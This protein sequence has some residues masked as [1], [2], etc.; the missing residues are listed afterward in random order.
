MSLFPSWLVRSLPVITLLLLIV[1]TGVVSI[2]SSAPMPPVMA[3][4]ACVYYWAMFQPSRLPLPALI[5][6]GLLQD[7][8]SGFPLGSSALCLLLLYYSTGNLRRLMSARHFWATWSGFGI[9]AL[10]MGI[11]MTICFSYVGR[12]E[13][14]DL[15]LQWFY[16]AGLSWLCYPPLHWICNRLYVA[17]SNTSSF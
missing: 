17:G 12:G 16:S 2:V 5:I 14:F 10:A 7:V 9:A 3:S 4:W 11:V 15:L 1:M 6:A 13:L 8:I